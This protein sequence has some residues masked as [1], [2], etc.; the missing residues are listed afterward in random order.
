MLIVYLMIMPKKKLLRESKEVRELIEEMSHIN[1][2]I[3]HFRRKKFSQKAI[4]NAKNSFLSKSFDGKNVSRVQK[5]V[6]NF[7]KRV[8]CEIRKI[9]N[10]P[11][12]KF[13]KN[14]LSK[15]LLIL[16]KKLKINVNKFLKIVDYS[17]GELFE[18]I[19]TDD[20]SRI[21]IR[22]LSRKAQKYLNKIIYS[23]SE[24]ESIKHQIR[25]GLKT[26]IARDQIRKDYV[27][28]DITYTHNLL[29]RAK[30]VYKLMEQD[31]KN[32]KKSIY[33]ESYIF[34][35]DRIGDKIAKAL[36]KKSEEFIYKKEF[37]KESKNRI[38]VIIDGLGSPSRRNKESKK[39]FY[40]LIEDMKRAGIEVYR[41]N[42]PDKILTRYGFF[43]FIR[44]PLITFFG[45]NHSKV[46]VIDDKI[47]YFGGMNISKDYLTY[48]DTH[49][50]IT[51]LPV[52]ELTKS[53]FK[54][55]T[56]C[57]NYEYNSLKKG[58][59]KEKKK[60]DYKE[61]KSE[62]KLEN[63]K[64]RRG[65]KVVVNFPSIINHAVRDEYLEFIRASK[66]C[67]YLINPYFVPGY[68]F[69]WALSKAAKRGVNVKI[70][71]S[72]KSDHPIVNAVAK[73]Y[74]RILLKRG[75]QIFHYNR[76]DIQMVHAKTMSVDNMYCTVGSS[77]LDYVSLTLNYETNVF[78]A[79][80]YIAKEMNEQFSKDLKNC[81]QVDYKKF[82]EDMKKRS[83]WQKVKEEIGYGLLGWLL[84]PKITKYQ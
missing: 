61:I 54:I 76:E 18:V 23:I 70:I 8:F 22:S 4:E 50:R 17:N 42:P 55:L 16:Q 38:I 58:F 28:N 52:M 7:E 68:R 77:N 33:L 5:R 1:E 46:L 39:K 65:Y 47:G 53:F 49:M 60:L 41:F 25:I 66:D 79:D 14:I 59:Y 80:T 67:I 43:S 27:L 74:Y 57:K 62:T 83:F 10:Q 40:N 32:A 35:S 20:F 45:R 78:F 6:N 29:F 36:I 2:F 9:K 34:D 21:K 81:I 64:K 75:V 15:N 69:V 56:I 82:K 37:S 30:E 11:M 72:E 19:R 63:K 13:K 44:H 12:A 71:L 3:R 84:M 26:F 48:R 51:G 24:L 73:K 31:I